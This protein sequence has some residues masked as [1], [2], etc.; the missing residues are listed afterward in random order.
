MIA[1]EEYGRQIC[2]GRLVVQPQG[3]Q[4]HWLDNPKAILE[5]PTKKNRIARRHDDARSCKG[6]RGGYQ[7]LEVQVSF[8][9]GVPEKGQYRDV[10]G[11]PF[12]ALDDHRGPTL[13]GIR[14]LART[15][16]SMNLHAN[17]LTI[18]NVRNSRRPTEHPI[19][20]ELKEILEA[21]ALQKPPLPIAAL[22][23][24]LY[25]IAIERRPAGDLA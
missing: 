14:Q 19:T 9:N 10:S 20:P 5:A 1:S 22:H 21:L 8:S 11:Y 13:H 7:C 4:R 25:R 23:R 3:H 16:V 17:A 6:F 24:Q 2:P 18:L 15:I 12:M